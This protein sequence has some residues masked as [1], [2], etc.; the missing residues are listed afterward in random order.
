VVPTAGVE[1]TSW[2]TAGKTL[3]QIEEAAKKV[4]KSP[5]DLVLIAVPAA[6]TPN[7]QS[8]PEEAVRS[9]AWILN[10]SL[11]FGRQQWDVVG[12]APSVLK[13]GPTPEEKAS[14]EFSRRMILAQDL[15]VVARPE[16]DEAL[17]EKILE[18]WLRDRVLVK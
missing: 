16:N 13:T 1:V 6:V 12:I 15:H 18:N 10:W 17:P 9:H 7:V 14:D 8:P 5:P 11:A 4:R 3:A 2:P